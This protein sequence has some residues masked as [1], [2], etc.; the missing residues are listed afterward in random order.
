MV[1][2]LKLGEGCPE[3]WNHQGESNRT[4]NSRFAGLYLK[5]WGDYPAVRIFQD[6]LNKKGN[7]VHG[8]Y[9]KLCEGFYLGYAMS[10]IKGELTS[11]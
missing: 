2:Y 10:R 4:G 1:R 7:L 9:L 8:R 6:E 11:P 3:G 5:L